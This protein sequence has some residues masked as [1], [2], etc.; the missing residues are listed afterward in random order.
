MIAPRLERS[1]LQIRE[2]GI[3]CGLTYEEEY[4]H[5][6]VAVKAPGHCVLGHPK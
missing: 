3:S 2:Q 4:I 5:P 1:I 6:K